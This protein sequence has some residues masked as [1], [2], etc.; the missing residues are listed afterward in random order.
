[1]RFGSF[2]AA[3][4]FFSA[5][6]ALAGCSGAH[7]PSAGALPAS[8]TGTTQQL[9]G[10]GKSNCQDGN[11]SIT[12]C[13]IKLNAQNPGPIDVYLGHQGQGN[14]HHIDEADNCASKGIATVTRVSNKHYTVTAGTMAGKCTAHFTVGGGQ[15]NG[16]R[17]P[18][19]NAL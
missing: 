6:L 14:R 10:D 15:G 8:T 7:A 1:M 13:P 12:P 5:S 2:Y 19:S 17:L 9:Q 16:A 3:A 11:M 4:A 18:I